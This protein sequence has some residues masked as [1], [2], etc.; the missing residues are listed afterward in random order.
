MN[1][2]CTLYGELGSVKGVVDMSPQEA[3]DSA[4]AFLVRQGYRRLRR[5]D[6]SLAM[7]RPQEFESGQSAPNLTVVA[8][9]QSDGGVTIRV[10]GN[11]REG[12]QSRQAAWQEWSQSLPKKPG[13]EVVETPSVPLAP[14]PQVE[15]PSLADPPQVSP[16]APPPPGEGSTVWRGT[17]LAFG[18]CVV[19]PILLLLGL[20]G[21]AVLLAGMGGFEETPGEE[22][23]PEVSSVAVRVSGSPNLQYSGNYGTTEGGGRSVDGELGVTPDEYQVPV[24]S[25]AF[26]FDMVTAFF[27]KQ[28]VEGT[29]RVEIIVNGQVV[30]SQ[31]T[32]AQYGVVDVTYSPQLD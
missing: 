16:V 4:E 30:K 6:I 9:P 28:G 26:D 23:A 12:M 5:T 18:G 7:A 2:G 27:Q 21:C 1:G 3:L 14:A 22:P 25:G 17:K 11:D 31:E 24:E 8:E 32:S 19:L 13:T 10:R 29:L 15:P 20:G